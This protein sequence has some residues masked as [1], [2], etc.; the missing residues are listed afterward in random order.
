ME[1]PVARPHGKLNR[2]AES[3]LA[4]I[5]KN[6]VPKLLAIIWV[7]FISVWSAYD[8]YRRNQLEAERSGLM[9]EPSAILRLN[10]TECNFVNTG[11]RALAEVT[12][13]W[14]YYMLDAQPCAIRLSGRSV[15]WKPAAEAPELRPRGQLKAEYAREE[16]ARLCHNREVM[17]SQGLSTQATP[18]SIILEC[19][20][21][22]H[23]AAD[24]RQYNKSRYAL[25]G[26][27]CKGVQSL[28][29]LYSVRND[30]VVWKDEKHRSVWACLSASWDSYSEM[31]R[32]LDTFAEDSDNPLRLEKGRMK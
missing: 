5:D 22:Y 10:G 13:S 12:L 24:L 25:V 30:S 17:R 15:S 19:R 26:E 16:L 32:R 29:T 1:K 23:R 2:I 21:Q 27:D 31:L 14:R 9:Y 7:V 11:N 18:P 8:G 28:E 3:I 6:P 20:A 4:W